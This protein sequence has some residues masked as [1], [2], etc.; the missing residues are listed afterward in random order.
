M[1]GGS[2]LTVV[3]EQLCGVE[4]VFALFI[5]LQS[6]RQSLHLLTAQD[7]TVYYSTLLEYTTV[8]C[9]VVHYGILSGY[10]TVVCTVVY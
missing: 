2:T 3:V 4:V 5:L 10:T 7:N 1:E 6:L 8:V 9:T